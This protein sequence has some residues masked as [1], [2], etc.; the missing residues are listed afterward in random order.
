MGAGGVLAIVVGLV[1]ILLVLFALIATMFRKVGPNQALIVYGFGG[2]KVVVGGG[3]VIWPMIQQGRE[4][5]LELMSFDVAPTQDLYTNQGVAVNVEAV[6]QIKVKSDEVSIKTAAE[7]FLT[8][9]PA[10]RDGLIRLV[11]EGHLRGI[12]GQLTVEQIVKEPEMVADRMRSNVADDMSKMGLEV[13]SFTIREVRDN[14]EYIVNMGKPDVASIRRSAD[15]AT[16]EADRD[17]AIRRAQASREAKIAEAAAEQEMVIAETA[18]QTRQAEAVRDLEI[19]RAEYASTVKAQQA[20]A[21]LAY[22]IQANIEK[23]KVVAEEVRVEQV[24][25]EGEI[26]VQEAEILRRE[27]ELIATVLK[28]A[29]VEKQRIEALAEADRNK[30][31]SIATGRSEAIKLE[32][33]AEAQAIL[34]RGNAEAGAMQTRATAYQE[35]NQAA[36]LDRLLTMMPELAKAL[37]EPLGRV[38]KITVVSTGDGSNGNGTGVNR[39]TADVATMVAQAPAMLEALTGITIGDLLKSV[40]GMNGHATAS[41]N[42]AKPQSSDGAAATTVVDVPPAM[43]KPA[44]PPKPAE[45]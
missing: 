35:Y 5:S 22:D 40:P 4:L 23:Q 27:K 17:T 14:N 7:Q 25:K 11:M 30:Q 31:I 12:V 37:A 2:T 3:K 38:D 41:H 16:A 45:S 26:S 24:R 19:K 33:L 20:Q 39:L 28:A 10:E 15:I 13:V 42:G 32:G 21:D 1:L 34:A 43:E 9:M 36:V 18:S 29:E 6:A 8:K 44:E